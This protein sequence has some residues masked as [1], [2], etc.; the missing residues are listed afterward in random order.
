MNA[1][2]E[3]ISMRKHSLVVLLYVMVF[4]VIQS[5]ADSVPTS[6]P[7]SVYS[8]SQCNNDNDCVNAGEV[9]GPAEECTCNLG[10]TFGGSP[11][12]CRECNRGYYKSVTGTGPC[13]ACDGGKFYNS[14]GGI[15]STVCESC[16]SGKYSGQGS[17]ECTACEAGKYNSNTMATQ[18]AEAQ[19]GYYTIDEDG[20][21]VNSAATAQSACASG[22]YSSA[23][24]TVCTQVDA[25]YFAVDGSDNSVNTAAVAQKACASGY[26]SSAGATVCTQVDA[27]YFAVDGSTTVS[28]RRQ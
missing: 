16:N 15:A 13:T 8:W 27:G 28:T 24:A 2:W 21:A 5:S 14:T 12:A 18:C 10:Y 26:Y 23:G 11:Q 25:G 4:L 22:Y 19:A 9:C 1:F 20:Q 17:S 3:K 7:T 6:Q